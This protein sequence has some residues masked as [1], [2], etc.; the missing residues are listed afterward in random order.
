[1]A[2]ETPIT[3]R[4]QVVQYHYRDGEPSLYHVQQSAT[5]P[6][7]KPVPGFDQIV[8][9]VLDH[10]DPDVPQEMKDLDTIVSD[11]WA[12]QTADIFTA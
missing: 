3:L 11:Y 8:V 4:E 6:A 7:G 9:K 5:N 1:M 10:A 12:A 2:K